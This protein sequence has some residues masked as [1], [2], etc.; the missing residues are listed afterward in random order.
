[1]TRDDE[2]M[3]RDDWDDLGL[4]G[5]TRYDEGMTRDDLDDLG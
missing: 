5:M 2:G 4:L 3:T 1:M